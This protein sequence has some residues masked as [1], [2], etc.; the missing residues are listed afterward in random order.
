MN[1]KAFKIKQQIILQN[2]NF[3]ILKTIL[4]LVILTKHYQKQNSAIERVM[5]KNKIK[6]INMYLN[7]IC[8][9]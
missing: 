2:F 1:V 5:N 8:R 3:K 4:S 9:L 7:W 6:D